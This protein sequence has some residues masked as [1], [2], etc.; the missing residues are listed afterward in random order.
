MSVYL[1][2]LPLVDLRSD[3]GLALVGAP[4][5]LAFLDR[6]VA[7]RAAAVVRGLGAPGMLVPSMAFLDRAD[8]AFNIVLFC[9][10]VPGG[11]AS[12]VGDPCPVGRLRLDVSD[13]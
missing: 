4:A 2:A 9:D 6:T 7:G 12:V 13:A 5:I 10:Q 11:L 1:Q 8:A 3:A